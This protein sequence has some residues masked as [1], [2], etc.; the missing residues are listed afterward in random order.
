MDQLTQQYIDHLLIEK[1]LS[2]N[3]IESYSHD[4][5][6]YIDFLY[7][8]KIRNIEQ[9]VTASILSWVIDLQKKEMSAK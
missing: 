9:T 1:G 7:K 3:S 4:L 8:N 6:V 2:N 5:S